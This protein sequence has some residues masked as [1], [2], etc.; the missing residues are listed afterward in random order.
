MARK[1]TAVEAPPFDATPQLQ[2]V[3]SL[4]S[5]AERPLELTP[6]DLGWTEYV[7]G[8]LDESEIAD[9]YPLSHGLRRIFEKIVGQII[10]I[11]ARIQ[12]YTP[13]NE[14]R[15]YPGEAAVQVTV[16]YAPTPLFSAGQF[17][18]LQ[19]ITEVA[20]TSPANAKSPYNTY[21]V[22]CSS[23]I[24]A[25]RCYR[26]GLRLKIIA[27][28]EVSGPVNKPLGVNSDGKPGPITGGQKAAIRIMAERTKTD[29]VKMASVMLGREI[30]HIDEVDAVLGMTMVRELNLW[31]QG[32]KE[33]PDTVKING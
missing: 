5:V 2:A 28:E 26:H 13:S 33:I 22:T 14:E 16:K 11:E 32:K 19:S 18:T 1:T 4:P 6:V 15:M 9:G 20:S 30:K 29:P 3:I 25:A 24:A 8:Q 17:G 23:T 7:M 31:Q 12:H 10:D 21:P 27:R